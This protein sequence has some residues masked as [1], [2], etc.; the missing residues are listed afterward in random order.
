MSATDEHPE[1]SFSIDLR[2]LAATLAVGEDGEPAL[3]AGDD[4]AAVVFETGAG[5]SYEH[6]ILGAERLAE[7]A[8]QLAAILR[9]RA[10]DRA[11]LHRFSRPDGTVEWWRP[12][13]RCVPALP[14]PA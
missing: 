11:P 12:G 7:R 1:V 2:G 10:G 8:E 3:T 13:Q 4:S 9:V 6:A 14:P 5:D